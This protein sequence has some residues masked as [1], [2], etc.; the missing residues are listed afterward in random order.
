M[1]E[2]FVRPA[3]VWAVLA[4]PRVVASLILGA[5]LMLAAHLLSRRRDMPA[6]VVYVTE[7]TWREIASQVLADALR[8]AVQADALVDIQCRRACRMTFRLTDGRL[9]E[10][11]GQI[12]RG[13]NSTDNARARA[14][15]GF[16]AANAELPVY[17]PTATHWR[18]RIEN[19]SAA[20]S[21]EYRIRSPIFR[22][23]SAALHQLPRPPS[24]YRQLTTRPCRFLP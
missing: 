4:D 21:D 20:T 16:F 9:C 23:S 1:P 7:H 17:L 12:S 22:R 6:E 15:W 13:R 5:A 8:E 24:S 11:Y 10:L 18:A 14:L 3:D 19:R 2:L